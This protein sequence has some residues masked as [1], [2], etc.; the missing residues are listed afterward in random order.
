MEMENAF[1]LRERWIRMNQRH[2]S[3]NLHVGVDAG[4][5]FYGLEGLDI[6][7]NRRES[8]IKKERMVRRVR[9]S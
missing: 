4:E 8:G 7:I 3:T 2:V 1:C 9:R 5:D 6:L